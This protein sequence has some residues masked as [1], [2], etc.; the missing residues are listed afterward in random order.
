MVVCIA[1]AFWVRE[2][3][4]DSRYKYGAA[5]FK[6]Y[7]GF[8]TSAFDRESRALS[9]GGVSW[10]LLHERVVPASRPAEAGLCNPK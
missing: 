9:G 5:R 10:A 1:L 2:L 4:L 3:A 6:W 7:R 8:V